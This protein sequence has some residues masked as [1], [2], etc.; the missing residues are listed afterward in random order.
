MTDI[1]MYLGFCIVG[2]I[3]GI[4]L[5]KVKDKL[6]WVG[7]AQSLSVIVLVFTM[8][9]RIGSNEQIVNN[10]GTY[11]I[12]SAIFTLVILF[13]SALVVSVFRRF[14]KIDRYG[15]VQAENEHIEVK[16]HKAEDEETGGK[17]DKMT[18]LIVGGVIIGI[19]AGYLLCKGVIAD[20]TA[21]ESG[22]S[23]AITIELCILLIFVGLDLGL[24]GQVIDN[25]KKAGLRILAVPLA[26]IIGTVAGSI[27]C[28]MILPVSM[29]ESLAIGCG[30][31]WYSLSA[32]LIMDAGYVSAGAISFMHNVM[33]EVFS[34]ILVPI[35]ARYIGYMEAVALP[36]AP[37]MDVCLPIVERSTNGTVA[38]YSFISGC[39]LSILVPFVVPLFL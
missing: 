28:A 9:I 29:K 20:M 17:F 7:A 25:F 12:Y 39:T 23:L 6:G 3:I 30:F 35:V 27:I 34:I 19:L 2:Y 10:L 24:E 13:M 15:M 5:R 32:G 22:I 36:G 16:E 33:R 18:F 31:G 37:G 4:P 26:I 38:M 21:F 8:G 11:G 14:L 1:A